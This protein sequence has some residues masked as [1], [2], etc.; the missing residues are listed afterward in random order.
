MSNR[1]AQYLGQYAEGWTTGDTARILDS[2]APGFVFTD[3]DGAVPK[4]TF[5]AYHARFKEQA[6]PT[7]NITGVVTYEVGDKLLACCYWE[8]GQIRGTGLIT[9]GN[10]GV[11]REDV[12]VL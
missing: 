12:A 10:D 1:Q 4:A 11:E 7:M 9:V 5:P 6:A 2:A 3:P 8:A